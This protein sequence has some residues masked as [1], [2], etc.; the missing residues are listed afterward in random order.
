MPT[1]IMLDCSLSMA[2]RVPASCGVGSAESAVPTT[3]F[4]LAKA[5]VQALLDYLLATLPWEYCALASFSSSCRVLEDFST[6]A[7]YLE[8]KRQLSLLGIEDKTLIDVALSTASKAIQDHFG[9]ETPCQL[10]LVTEARGLQ[11]S[12]FSSELV[13]PF[14]V[15]LQVIALSHPADQ[16]DH[17]ALRTLA[18]RNSG[19][20]YEIDVS[21]GS[22]GIAAAISQLTSDHFRPFDG[23]LEFGALASPVRLYP[24]PSSLAGFGTMALPSCLRVVRFIASKDLASPAILSRHVV[25]PPHT[26]SDAVKISAPDFRVVLYT[27]L[28]Q[29]EAVALVD[30]GASWT[31][32]LHCWTESKK[33]NLVLSV[34]KPGWQ[35][36]WI[37]APDALSF[38]SLDKAQVV[39]LATHFSYSSEWPKEHALITPQVLQSDLQR[40]LRYARQ[41][42][43]KRE[44][45]FKEM[46][47]LRS[48]IATYG[49]TSLHAE[50]A[51]L[52]REEIAK[53]EAADS[54]AA[55]DGVMVLKSAVEQ[56]LR[57]DHSLPIVDTLPT[58]E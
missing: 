8:M 16:A 38:L 37:D 56:W 40:A 20:L 36:P 10:V 1:L 15:K 46:N 25:V 33:N 55:H 6:E 27:A 47:K 53:Q 9:R 57:A 39:Q 22:S 5:A 23:T 19:G 42:A 45:F 29:Q 58:P 50:V 44:G 31:G 21:Q 11:G 54:D 26:Q 48:M 32:L 28:R 3:R 41:I 51:A 4:D 2:R 17:T 12:T 18:S 7:N 35:M 52:L 43:N 34:L 14:P 24:P 30:L 49:M 13:F